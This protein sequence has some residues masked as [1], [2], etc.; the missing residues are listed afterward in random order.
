MGYF[1]L[2]IN[3][4]VVQKVLDFLCSQN[5]TR[6]RARTHTHTHTQR[7]RTRASAY[8]SSAYVDLVGDTASAWLQEAAGISPTDVC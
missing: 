7:P 2:N 3:E 4:T 8:D 1:W 6:A 5:N